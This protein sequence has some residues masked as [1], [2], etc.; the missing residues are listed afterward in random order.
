MTS[1]RVDGPP[2]SIVSSL[3]TAALSYADRGWL[4]VAVEGKAPV[5]GNEWPKRASKTRTAVNC[6]P[7]GRV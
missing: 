2:T 4:V 5:G 3:I 7:L 1:K 6:V